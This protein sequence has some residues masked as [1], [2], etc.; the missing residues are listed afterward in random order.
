MITVIAFQ[1]VR[2]RCQLISPSVTAILGCISLRVEG[3]TI[4]KI[5][6]NCSKLYQVVSDDNA[7][8]KQYH[9]P[10]NSY[11]CESAVSWIQDYGSKHAHY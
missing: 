1:S 11:V 10:W 9:P 5:Y 4:Y 6:S 3:V 2:Q 7:I 8:F